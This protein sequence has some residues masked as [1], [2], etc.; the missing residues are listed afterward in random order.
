MDDKQPGIYYIHGESK[1]CVET[2]PFMDKLKKNGYELLY[3]VDPID[4][5]A[6]QQLIEFDWKKLLSATK[7]GL[8]IEEDDDEKKAFEE[9]KAKT[10]GHCKLMK[11]VLDDKVEKVVITNRRADSHCCLLTR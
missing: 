10:K 1:R 8:Q 6:V 9:A 2:S 7:E 11:Q 3:M 5:Y 4:E